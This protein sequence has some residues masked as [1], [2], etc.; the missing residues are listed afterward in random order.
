MI[1][2]HTLRR[3]TLLATV[4]ATLLATL[5]T[6]ATML[7]QADSPPTH[8]LLADDTDQGVTLA[9]LAASNGEWTAAAAVDLLP[10]QP[11]GGYNLPL[12]T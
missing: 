6:P 5:L 3:A 2:N 9:W 8:A 1:Q 4:I 10:T 11:Y 12:Q 7:A